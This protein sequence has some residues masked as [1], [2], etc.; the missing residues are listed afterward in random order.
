MEIALIILGVGTFLLLGII[1]FAIFS[2]IKSQTQLKS[3]LKE[4]ND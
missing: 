1:V 3:L 2:Y 4:N